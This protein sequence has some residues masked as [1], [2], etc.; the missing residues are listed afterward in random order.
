MG[1]IGASA[2]LDSIVQASPLAVEL[3]VSP[4]TFQSKLRQDSA[5]TTPSVLKELSTKLLIRND[6]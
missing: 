2:F 5:N 6:S 4:E 3:E 1:E